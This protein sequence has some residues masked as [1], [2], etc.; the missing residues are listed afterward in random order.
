MCSVFCSL[1]GGDKSYKYHQKEEITG[2]AEVSTN[3]A[4]WYN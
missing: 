4:Y 2:V 3:I 1:G